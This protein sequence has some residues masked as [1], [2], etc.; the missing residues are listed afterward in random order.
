MD[1]TVGERVVSRFER[2]TVIALQV[3]IMTVVALATVVLYVLL[4]NGLRMYAGARIESTGDLIPLMQRS[5]AGV[6]IVVL[7][8][9]LLETLRVYF[10][11]LHVRVEM[12]LMVAITAV[13]REMVQIDYEHTPGMVLFGLALVLLSLTAGYFLVS[14]ARGAGAKPAKSAEEDS[15]VTTLDLR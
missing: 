4:V 9:E 15:A 11:T 14:R 8:L 3:L 7:G 13:G 5:F 12:V 6:L 1:S 10:T 2:I